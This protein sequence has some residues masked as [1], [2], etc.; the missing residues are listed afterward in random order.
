MLH[1]CKVANKI[2]EREMKLTLSPLH[3]VQ[4]RMG[5]SHDRHDMAMVLVLQLITK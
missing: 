2:K 1:T 3:A 4:D 5:K